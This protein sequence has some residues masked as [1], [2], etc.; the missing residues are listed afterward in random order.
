MPTHLAKHRKQQQQEANQVATKQ[1]S[2]RTWIFNK[3][4]D[5]K[6]AELLIYD[7]IGETW[8]GEGVTAKN[9]RKDLKALGDIESLD[10]R[11]N[12]PGGNVFDGAAIY[13]ALKETKY[14]VHVHVDGVAASMASVI[15]MAGDTVTMHECALMMIHNP[16][17]VVAG[18]SHEMRRQAD[19][20][21]KVKS[22]LLA[23]YETKTG[24]T[25]DEI[26]ALMDAETW[27]DA[28]EAKKYGIVDEIVNKSKTPLI[29][30][31]E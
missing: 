3:A 20:L 7:V 25:R 30:V 27:M 13:Q 1:A 28:S 18:D 2:K 23:A 19:L 4:A 12:S 15:A 8:W 10:V 24:S 26:S 17:S 11:I 21:D 14:P 9:F 16:S 5:K 29:K 22:Q 6:S 31:P